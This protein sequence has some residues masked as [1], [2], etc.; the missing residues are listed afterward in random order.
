MPNPR[1]ASRYAKS[2]IDLSIEKDR[3]EEVYTDMQWL[4]AICKASRDFVV[5]LRSPVIK[6]D[7]KEKIIDIISKGKIG[8]LT[9]A[10][11]MLMI[12]KGR[13]SYLPEVISAFISQYKNNKNI[14][15]V[16]LITAS[17]ISN[18]LRDAIVERIKAT[19]EL[20][21]IELETVVDKRLIGGFILQAGD[22]LVEGSIAKDLKQIAK[23]FD[24]NDFIYKLR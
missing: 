14:H 23:Q 2:L 16:K 7:K 13:E 11:I 18:E 10:F 19:S 20:Q 12:R 1:L 9:R 3:L 15:Q 5:L 22:K 8:E 17:P 24:N 6:G 21:N 4:N